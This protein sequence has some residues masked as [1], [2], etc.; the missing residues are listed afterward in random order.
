MPIIPV[1]KV[2]ITFH[3]SE[4]DR[5][6]EKLQ[7]SGILHIAEMG[8]EIREEFDVYDKEEEELEKGLEEKVKALERVISILEKYTEPVGF[9]ESLFEKKEEISKNELLNTVSSINIDERLEEL[10]ALIQDNIFLD[11]RLKNLYTQ[12]EFLKPWENLDLSLETFMKG[13][14]KIKFIAGKINIRYLSRIKDIPFEKVFEDSKFAYI[15]IAAFSE[16]IDEIKK[17][18]VELEFEQV[19]FHGYRFTPREELALIEKEIE[20][21]E[22]EK[23][24]IDKIFSEHARNLPVYR[25]LHDYY[26]SILDRELVDAKGVET[27]YATF[28]TGWVEKRNI[29][30]LEEI[31]N[32]FETATW[33]KIEPEKGEEPPI[34]LENK[35]LLRPF[36]T[37]VRLYGLP[38]Y[39]E[40]DPTPVMAPFF[41]IFFALCLTDA[42]YGIVLMLLSYYLMKKIKAGYDLFW[43]LFMGGF[44]T[45]FA[46]AITGGWFGDI[47]SLWS[48]FNVFRN[49]FLLFDPMN[50]PM[51]FFVVAMALGYI[52]IIVGLF[53]GF[54][55]KVKNGAIINGIANEIAWIGILIS[56][57]LGIYLKKHFLYYVAIGFAVLILL[58]SA[59]SKNPIVRVLK[60]AYNLYEGIGFIGDLL[61]YVRLMAL[62]IV[63]A[64]IAMA[65]NI[66]VKLV[67]GIPYLG[68][69]LAPLIF[70]G[71][72]AFSVFVNVMGAFVHSLRLQYVE[73]FNKFYENGGKAFVPFS[74]KG[75]YYK[76]K[77][78]E[79]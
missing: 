44:A 51:K 18:L 59:N 31:I 33:M 41:T 42:G 17:Q 26:V 52:Q 75:K 76:V 55:K 40:I 49:K 47:Q 37:L 28:I 19:E 74:W 25:K 23:R 50:E 60:G 64:G 6:L 63:T 39:R 68:Y 67:L 35:K 16:D 1:E 73:F 34:Y 14:G 53:V 30:K 48:G 27:N 57:P 4:K 66:L 69:I 24:V 65:I 61:S 78:Q 45:I 77:T 56:L 21:L 79:E 11:T 36:E 71:G 10:G 22:E 13:Y 38:N 58:L 8:E 29:K 20:V 72:H 70:I 32:S 5:I 7:D 15:I 12:V 54:Y 46:G 3:K 62:G 2:Y 9:L 43:T